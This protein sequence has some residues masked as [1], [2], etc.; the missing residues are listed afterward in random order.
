MEIYDLVLASTEQL[1]TLAR[2]ADELGLEH[3]LPAHVLA[4][5]TPKAMHT[6]DLVSLVQRDVGYGPE[7]VVRC[8]V[9]VSA[10]DGQKA[11]QVKHF[12]VRLRDWA[13]LEVPDHADEVQHAD[14]DGAS[15]IDAEY[16]QPDDR[17]PRSCEEETA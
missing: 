4:A 5:A 13:A 10:G 16:L 7:H 11:L 12:D 6:L 1:R 2:N 14:G 9:Q 15:Q 8:Q 17:S 3:P